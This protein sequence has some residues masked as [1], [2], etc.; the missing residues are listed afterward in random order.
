VIITSRVW[1]QKWISKRLLPVIRRLVNINRVPK[2]Y[3]IWPGC[4]RMVS[5]SIRISI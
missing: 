3:I 2:L 5:V 4:T 1:E